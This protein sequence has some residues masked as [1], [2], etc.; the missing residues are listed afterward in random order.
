MAPTVVPSRIY[1]TGFMGCG[2]STLAPRLAR[3]LGYR[4]VDLDEAIEDAAGMSVPAIFDLEGEDSFRARER[5]MLDASTTW[6]RVVVATGGGALADEENMRR[7]LA[8]GLVLYMEVAPAE[9]VRRLRYGA[10]HRPLLR[11]GRGRPLD[12]HVMEDK[13]RETLARRAP[14]YRRADVIL[15]VRDESA[16]EVCERALRLLGIPR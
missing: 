16:D 15:P 6:E 4:S 2:K 11:D 14:V 12:V 8:A 10:R 9:L 5:A 13:I 7:A 3:A 1:L